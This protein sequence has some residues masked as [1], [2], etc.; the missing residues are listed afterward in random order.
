MTPEELRRRWHETSPYWVMVSNE[1]RARARHNSAS[2]ARTAAPI[3]E[4]IDRLLPQSGRAVELGSGTGQHVIEFARCRPGIEWIPSD[5]HPAGRRSIAAWVAHSGCPNVR[6]PLDL[7]LTAEEWERAL[8]PRCQ[9]MVAVNVL[10]VT[11]WSAS[12]GLLRGAASRLGG[13]GLLVIYG[14]FKRRGRHL[15]TGNAEFERSLQAKD[16]AWGIRDVDDLESVAAAH[17]MRLAEV[18]EMPAS[19]LMLVFKHR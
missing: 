11:P 10:Q 1:S 17:A 14:C 15:S 19:N 18:V 8:E 4:Q 16:P 3:R 7:D 6:P 9:A 13:D 12:L 2:A 5:P